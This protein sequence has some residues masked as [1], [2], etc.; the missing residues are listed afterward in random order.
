VLAAQGVSGFFGIL[1]IGFFASAT[2]NGVQDGLLFGS[3]I[4]LGRQAL[5]ASAST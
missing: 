4:Q 1:L 2:W 5:A 3:P